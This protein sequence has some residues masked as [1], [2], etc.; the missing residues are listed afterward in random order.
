[1]REVRYSDL[2]R[3]ETY[4][5][6]EDMSMGKMIFIFQ[7][8]DSKPITESFSIIKVLY[9]FLR[10]ENCDLNKRE[11]FIVSLFPCEVI[12]KLTND[13]VRDQILIPT[14]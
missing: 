1:M 5:F 11:N 4:L 10:D 2:K 9:A 8:L 7:L 13:E 12:Y 14:I 6:Y 3:G